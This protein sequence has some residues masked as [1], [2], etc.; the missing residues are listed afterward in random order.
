M[1]ALRLGLL[2]LALALAAGCGP[3]SNLPAKVSGKVTYNNQ[4]VPGGNIVFHSKDQGSYSGTLGESGTYEIEGLPAGDLVVTIETETL[5]PKNKAPA[6]AGGRG[7]ANDK[8]YEEAMKKMGRP[9]PPE[10]KYVKIP[11]KYAKEDTSG[12]TVTLKSGK[13]TKDFSLTD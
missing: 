6:Y 3:H 13:Q 9:V 12:L 5:N 8:Q 4:P 10:T 2:T 11:A 1:R 7:A